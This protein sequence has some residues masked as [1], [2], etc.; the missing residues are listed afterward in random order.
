M[1][2]AITKVSSKGQIV[3]PSELRKNI[4]EGD[5]FLIIRSNNQFILKRCEDLAEE[6]QEDIEFAQ[7]TEAA[8]LRISQ[9]KGVKMEFDDFIE[10]MGKW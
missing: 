2:I 5:K 8:L 10:E 7:R 1:E 4:D 6:M 9:G 3:L